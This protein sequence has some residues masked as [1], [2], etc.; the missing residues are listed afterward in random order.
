M[1]GYNTV[2]YVED[3]VDRERTTKRCLVIILTILT[4]I[5]SGLIV[6]RSEIC[7][8]GPAEPVENIDNSYF[9]VP[10][11][12]DSYYTIDIS[13]LYVKIMI[14]EC[15]YLSE[16]SS[17]QREQLLFEDFDYVTDLFNT[18]TIPFRD[19]NALLCSINI[20]GYNTKWACSVSEVCTNYDDI[21][22]IQLGT[23][24]IILNPEA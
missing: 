13:S 21:Q 12:N 1:P 4:T 19:G 9:I 15:D 6:Y 3:F 17:E 24:Y 23:N 2:Q 20:Q 5:S 22:L 11:E 18:T 10:A 8:V 16:L 14:Y 7:R